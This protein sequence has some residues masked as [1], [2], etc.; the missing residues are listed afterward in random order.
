M[1]GLAGALVVS[2]LLSRRRRARLVQSSKTVS[3]VQVP[4]SA[5]VVVPV[6]SSGD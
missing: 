1:G 3:L 6:E 5:D 2:I 4:V